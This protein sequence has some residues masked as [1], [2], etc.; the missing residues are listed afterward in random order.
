MRNINQKVQE[1]IFMIIVAK[2]ALMLAITLI[3]A[4]FGVHVIYHAKTGRAGVNDPAFLYL[5]DIRK[6]VRRS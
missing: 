2:F 6:S 1:G 3:V 4:E 5:A